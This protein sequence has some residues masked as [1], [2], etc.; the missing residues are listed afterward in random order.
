[1]GSVSPK[2]M[3]AKYLI[4]SI[5]CMM[6]TIKCSQ[7]WAW[8][9]TF[10]V[11]S[12]SDTEARCGW[13]ALKE[14]DQPFL[15]LFRSSSFL[16]VVEFALQ[17]IQADKQAQDNL[18][19]LQVHTQVLVQAAGTP[20]QHEVLVAIAYLFAHNLHARN[21]PGLGQLAQHL[22]FQAAILGGLLLA[23]V[24]SCSADSDA[25]ESLLAHSNSSLSSCVL[26]HVAD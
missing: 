15:C 10:P 9:Y 4:A 3:K 2:S 21:N 14:R 25:G 16:S 20:Q 8:G 18:D 17:G 12:L 24:R 13:K 6:R 23:I 26:V 19:A 7:D 11:R 22:Y 1:M 5:V